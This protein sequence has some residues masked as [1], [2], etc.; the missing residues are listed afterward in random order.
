VS[1]SAVPI[2]IPLAR[3]RMPTAPS[4]VISESFD[5][6]PLMV[7][8]PEVSPK[9]KPDIAP[10]RT[11]GLRSARKSGLRP[12]RERFWSCVRSIVLP[13]VADSVFNC[14]TLASTLM[15]SV[16]WPTVRST[17][18]ASGMAASNLL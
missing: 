7:I 4:K 9:L 16:I 2:E 3:V 18:T 10:P 1:I 8:P 13:T 12:F 11:P 6:P 15:D 17:L 14:I 5:R